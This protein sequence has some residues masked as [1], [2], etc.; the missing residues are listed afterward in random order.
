MTGRSI[1]ESTGGVAVA[2][3]LQCGDKTC[4]RRISLY[5]STNKPVQR[6]RRRPAGPWRACLAS[7]RSRG[8]PGNG[9]SA[10]G[11]PSR[12]GCLPLPYPTWL[13]IVA[14]EEEREEEEAVVAVWLWDT[15]DNSNSTLSFPLCHRQKQTRSAVRHRERE[16]ERERLT[17]RHSSLGACAARQHHIQI[18]RPS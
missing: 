12:R 5:S 13:R 7:Q 16:R 14:A 9:N 2:G 15:L 18:L 17:D 6:L 1:D 3:T 8:P 4:A 11:Q 10:S